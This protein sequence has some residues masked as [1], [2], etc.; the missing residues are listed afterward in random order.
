MSLWITLAGQAWFMALS[1]LLV[2]DAGK[3]LIDQTAAA[4]RNAFE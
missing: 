4:L 1:L 3:V 2:L